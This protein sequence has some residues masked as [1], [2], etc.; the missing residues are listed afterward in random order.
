[1]ALLVRIIELVIIIA[2]IRSFLRMILPHNSEKPASSGTTPKSERF[3]T[4]QADISDAD[5]EDIT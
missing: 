5:Y 3:N 2:V 4:G 1:V